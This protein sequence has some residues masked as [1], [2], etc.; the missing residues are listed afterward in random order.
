MA[1]NNAIPLKITLIAIEVSFWSMLTEK[2][3]SE[4]PLNTNADGC[5]LKYKRCM[6]VCLNTNAAWMCA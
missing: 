5:V 3:K 2:F 1:Q 6:D 4:Y